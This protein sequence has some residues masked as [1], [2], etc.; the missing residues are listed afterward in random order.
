MSAPSRLRL[1][2]GELVVSSFVL[3]AMDTKDGSKVTCKQC[4]PRKTTMKVLANVFP[5]SMFGKGFYTVYECANCKRQWAIPWV[6][7]LEGSNS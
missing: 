3:P 5:E 6:D 4:A 1:S 2:V 7:G